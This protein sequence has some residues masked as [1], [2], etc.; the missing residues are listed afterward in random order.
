MYRGAVYMIENI[1][2]YKNIHTDSSLLASSIEEFN[3]HLR[4]NDNNYIVKDKTDRM[5]CCQ[6]LKKK[7]RAKKI[8]SDYEKIKKQIKEKYRF[9]NLYIKNVPDSFDDEALRKIFVPFGEIRS[10]K[11]VRKEL[12]T[13]YLGIKRSVKI[14]G[15][16]CY[17]DKEH[18]RAAKSAL[19]GT[20]VGN[21][22]AKL[23]VDYHQ[24]KQERNEFLKLRFMNST[25]KNQQRGM[26]VDMRMPM[27]G[28]PMMMG[29]F[30]F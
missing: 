15:F 14:F 25:Q 28:M 5:D 17:F 2:N 20:Q 18:A 13:S 16:V 10:C 1:E 30:F 12:F 21:A 8:K 23:F 9:C 29:I 6:A 4:A 24:N 11:A 19:H 7:E 22:G 26:K 3:T 27:G